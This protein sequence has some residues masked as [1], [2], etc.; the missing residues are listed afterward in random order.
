M[1]AIK[2]VIQKRVSCRAQRVCADSACD[3]PMSVQMV[4][5]RVSRGNFPASQTGGGPRNSATNVSLHPQSVSAAAWPE[6]A[7]WLN[8]HI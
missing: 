5:K 4:T 2:C 3:T 7:C 6:W 1:H 8:A